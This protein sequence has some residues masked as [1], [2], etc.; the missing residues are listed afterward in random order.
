MSERRTGAEL[1]QPPAKTSCRPRRPAEPGD[2]KR[3]PD[4]GSDGHGKTW[5]DRSR[6][7]VGDRGACRERPDR[8]GGLRRVRRQLVAML[9]ERARPEGLRLTGRAPPACS[10]ALLRDRRVPTVRGRTLVPLPPVGLAVTPP[11]RG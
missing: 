1:L 2:C 11:A 8:A 4:G 9:A 6:R 7:G 3:R 5:S 10:A